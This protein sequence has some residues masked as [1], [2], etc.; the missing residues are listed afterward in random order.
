MNAPSQFDPLLQE[1]SGATSIE[2][3]A[4]TGKTYSITLLWLRL[5]VEQQLRVD[6]ILV[7]TFTQAA[8]AELR[9][10]LLA[11][12]RRAHAAARALADGDEPSDSP[13]ARIIRRWL[14]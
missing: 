13:E 6:Q 9:E 3:S 14:D 7:S 12:L 11:S 10:R 8:T 4:G 2:A 5:L 1:L